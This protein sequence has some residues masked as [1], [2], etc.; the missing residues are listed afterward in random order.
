[1]ASNFMCRMLQIPLLASLLSMCLLF[2]AVQGRRNISD[3][4]HAYQGIYWKTALRECPTEH[5]DIL[6]ESTRMM[7]ELTEKN[8]KPM[9]TPGW[10]RFFVADGAGMEGWSSE[11]HLPDYLQVQ[12]IMT[13]VNLFPR[14][15]KVGKGNKK[16]DYQVAYRCRSSRRGPCPK[17]GKTIAT[18]KNSHGRW[19]MNFCEAFFSHKYL[20][21][22]TNGEKMTAHKLGS[23]VSYEHLLAHDWTFVD[24]LGSSFHVK[25]L[26]AKNDNRHIKSKISGVEWANFFAWYWNAIPNFVVKYSAENYAW[27]W[28]NNW[29]NE[30]WDWKDNGLDPQWGPTTNTSFPGSPSE[31]AGPGAVVPLDIQTNEQKNCHSG[32]DPRESFCDYIGEPY[33]DWLKDREKS[34]TSEGGCELTNAGARLVIMPLTPLASVRVMAKKL[35]SL[36]PGVLVSGEAR[37]EVI[38]MFSSS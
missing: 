10:Q 27:F 3:I 37:P 2:P 4:E 36:I 13:Q 7:L 12:N 35:R 28:T 25:D 9:D 21:D 38:R 8:N 31:V 6:V 22:I 33:G 26:E 23:L 16:R 32:N 14:L 17:R 20:N 1:M 5:F 15:G 24:L 30:K 34:F 18:R 29:F 19:E 11:K